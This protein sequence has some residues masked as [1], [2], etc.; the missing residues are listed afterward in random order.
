MSSL[1]R[2]RN[3]LETMASRTNSTSDVFYSDDE[4]SPHLQ[5][6]YS[7]VSNF[8]INSSE[9]S[10]LMTPQ[11]M[12]SQEE[13]E[14]YAHIQLPP[15]RTGSKIPPEPPVR[16]S[17]VSSVRSDYTQRS[18]PMAYDHEHNYNYGNYTLQY[19]HHYHYQQHSRRKTWSPNG[20]K[21]SMS[22]GNYTG[23][24]RNC[25]SSELLDNN[26]R[27]RKCGNVI[28][29]DQEKG[30][31]KLTPVSG[32]LS[33]SPAKGII[34]PIAFKPVVIGTN[35]YIN[36]DNIPHDGHVTRHNGVHQSPHSVFM[37]SD[38]SSSF[39]SGSAKHF[40]PDRPDIFSV[41]NVSRISSSHMD[42]YVGTP[43]P[44]D[45]GVGELEAML[46]EKD[47]EINTLREVMDKNER[48]IFQVYDEKKKSWAK[49]IHDIKGDF[50][51][52]LKV[53]QRKAYKTEQ[54]LSL[55]SYKSQQELKSTQ[56]ELEKVKFEND[57]LKKKNDWI[58]ARYS[59]MMSLQGRNSSQS[60]DFQ[61]SFDVTDLQN[62]VE[63][64]NSSLVKQTEDIQLLQFRLQEK[65]CEIADRENELSKT[66]KEVA[67]KTEEVKSLK[68]NLRR[69]SGDSDME[70]MDSSFCSCDKEIQTE[71]RNS[72]S[73]PGSVGINSPSSSDNHSDVA[74]LRQE[75]KELREALQIKS[76]K[77]EKEREQWKDEKNKVIRYQKQLQLNYLQMY[78]KNRMLEAEVE[79]LTLDLE[80]RDIKLMAING[81]EESM[82]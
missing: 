13:E 68:A 10:G 28:Y 55:Q 11:R 2:N 79:Q 81:G 21:L 60:S 53:M 47:A 27:T 69:V 4:F 7:P 57:N 24:S 51:Q 39:S 6:L 70:L 76:D 54:V 16:T 42:G 78:N 58:E 61:H 35:S 77:F 75:I 74:L 46:R 36:N 37:E 50:D 31:P 44:S 3:E 66:F 43:S 62:K 20:L 38:R 29:E 72:V 9:L 22:G 19:P 73:S 17:S 52:K 1:T 18:Y 40:S 25:S 23:R 59:D 56:Q 80:N 63:D 5:N 65:E 82:C 71:F 30:P 26:I 48:A 45:S 49:E 32:M 41:G 15:H 33:K 34:K 67:T 64:L 12:C 8:S 14:D